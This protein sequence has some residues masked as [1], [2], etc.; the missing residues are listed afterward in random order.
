MLK[1]NFKDLLAAHLN[2]EW[3]RPENALCDTLA[4]TLIQKYEMAPPSLDLGC[5][6]GIFTFITAGGRFSIDYDWYIN[7]DPDG[8]WQH[9][10]IYNVCKTT[11]IK[12]FIIQK[13]RYNFNFGLD[14]KAPLLEQAKGLGFYKAVVNADANARLPFSEGQFCTIFSNI[15]YWLSDLEKSLGELNRVSS[16]NATLIICMPSKNFFHYCLSYQW[17]KRKSELLRLLNKG[18]SES[19]RWVISYK[20]FSQ[21]AKKAGFKVVDHS[22]YLSPIIMRIWDIGLRPISPF[23]IKM[24]NKLSIQD[25][26]EIK[27]EWLDTVAKFCLPLYEKEKKQ[28]GEGGFQLFV[29]RK[30]P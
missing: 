26:R 24:A 4:S 8:F 7:T 20:E 5:G 2:V 28:K 15:L 9:K 19:M 23:L 1:N 27:K 14:H 18:R 25:R 29:L 16:K 13:P 12:R 21:A 11:D 22:Y 3:L 30:R 10:D 6:N 17:K